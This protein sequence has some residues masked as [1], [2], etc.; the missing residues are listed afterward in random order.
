MDGEHWHTQGGDYAGT[1]DAPG[2]LTLDAEVRSTTEEELWCVEFGFDLMYTW[3]NT[4]ECRQP[5]C[6]EG[7]DHKSIHSGREC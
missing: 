6:A 3:Q 2:E 4:W 1:L 7:S 5:L